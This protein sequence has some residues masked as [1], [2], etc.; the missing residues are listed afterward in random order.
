MGFRFRVNAAQIGHLVLV[1]VPGNRLIGS[2][3]ELFNDFVTCFLPAP[4]SPGN[5]AVIIVLKNRFGHFQF[6]GATGQATA[7]KQFRQVLHG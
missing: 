3:H 1:Q 7:V 5:L 2:Q 6:K 4:V